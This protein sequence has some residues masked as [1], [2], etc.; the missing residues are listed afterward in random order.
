M[1]EELFLWICCGLPGYLVT[2]EGLAQWCEQYAGRQAQWVQQNGFVAE[3]GS[4]LMVPDK[5]GHVEAVLVGQGKSV[6]YWSLG[7]LVEKL[8]EGIYRLANPP[9]TKASKL[10]LWL[11]VGSLSF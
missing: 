1:L 8:P 6:D 4:V 3:R 10:R 2:R 7:N 5:S 11:G 9:E